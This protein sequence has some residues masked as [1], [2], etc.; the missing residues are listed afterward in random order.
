MIVSDVCD[1]RSGD[2]PGDEAAAQ[3]DPR[4]DRPPTP[5][6]R[7]GETTGCVG[8]DESPPAFAADAA[9]HDPKA[10]SSANR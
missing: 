6:V 3:D 9:G 10:G 5:A 4:P 8:A 2:L 1:D 7:D